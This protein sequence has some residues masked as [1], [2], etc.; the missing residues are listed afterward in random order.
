[1]DYFLVYPNPAQDYILIDFPLPYKDLN[2]AFY[3]I[4]GKLVMS[5]SVNENTVN[6]SK[7]NNG[8]YILKVNIDGRKL[9]KKIVKE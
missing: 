3:D 5:G 7:L 8:A 2:Y 1:M 6:I 9:E 4:T